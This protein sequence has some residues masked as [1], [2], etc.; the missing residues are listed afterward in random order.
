MMETVT[1]SKSIK[2]N[3]QD[4]KSSKVELDPKS[5]E[6]VVKNFAFLKEH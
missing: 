6:E 1:K 2:I 5:R 4:N 3:Y